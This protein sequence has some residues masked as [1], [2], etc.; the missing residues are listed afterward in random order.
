MCS[1]LE[2]LCCCTEPYSWITWLH[3]CRDCLCVRCS[4]ILVL[5]AVLN[6]RTHYHPSILDVKLN[7][8][9]CSFIKFRTVEGGMSV[10]E[11]INTNPKVGA[12]K[13]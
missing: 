3:I 1:L 9:P 5:L 11:D 10:S 7:I 4:R 2:F 6:R 13:V 12:L 8:H